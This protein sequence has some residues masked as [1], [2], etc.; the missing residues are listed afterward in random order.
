MKV[1][2]G[3]AHRSDARG[4]VELP[5]RAGEGRRADLLMGRIEEMRFELPVER[6]AGL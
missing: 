5:G 1:G 3:A 6:P 2:H 4:V